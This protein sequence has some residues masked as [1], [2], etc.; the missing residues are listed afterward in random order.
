MY[1]YLREDGTPWY[2]GKGTKGR[3][4]Y[5]APKECIHTPK[6]YS[7]VVILESGLSNVGACSIERRMIRWYGRMDTGPGILRNKT[8]GGDGATGA[9]FSSIHKANLSAA[10]RGKKQTDATRKKRSEKLKGVKT[11]PHSDERILNISKGRK[12]IPAHNKGVAMSPSQK[13]KFIF[14]VEC[15][16]CHKL[17]QNGAMRRWHFDNC[18]AQS[19]SL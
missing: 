14:I 11:G 3:A 15:P 17:G 16:Q 4:W 6:D 18:A 19:S 12:G 7:R 8:D 10:Q 13:E 5:H 1:A 2:I 9:K